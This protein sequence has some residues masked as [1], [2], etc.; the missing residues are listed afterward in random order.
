MPAENLFGR[1]A[2]R[3]LAAEGRKYYVGFTIRRLVA[4][5]IT[6]NDP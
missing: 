6:S 1:I 4:F 3:P 2:T 5:W